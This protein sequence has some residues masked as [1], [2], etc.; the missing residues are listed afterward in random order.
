MEGDGDMWVKPARWQQSCAD[1]HWL[2]IWH[3][4]YLSFFFF[5]LFLPHHWKHLERAG[6]NSNKLPP[7]SKPSLLLSSYPAASE[8]VLPE[9]VPLRSTKAAGWDL[10][11]KAPCERHLRSN[12][13]GE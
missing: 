10:A 2:W 4:E 7:I 8:L 12:W 13:L 5:F 11:W 6:R 1:L 9:P 3:A